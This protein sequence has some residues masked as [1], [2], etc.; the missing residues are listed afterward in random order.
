L[1]FVWTASGDDGTT[2]TAS[3]YDIRYGKNSLADSTAFL[4]ATQVPGCTALIPLP[5]GTSESWTTTINLEC[6]QTY[7][8][9]MRVGDEIINWSPISN[10]I[11]KTTQ[12]CVAPA[13]IIDFGFFN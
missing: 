9:A 10:V 12:D 8:F 5:A 2:G 3:H 11:F 1:T 7:Y 6:N 4:S 13:A